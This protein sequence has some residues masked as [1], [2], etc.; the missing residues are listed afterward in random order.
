MQAGSHSNPMYAQENTDMAEAFDRRN[1]GALER[2]GGGLS[3]AD[4][5]RLSGDSPHP[6]LRVAPDGRIVYANAASRP[7]L[8]HWKS[9]EAGILPSGL[10]MLLAPL[11]KSGAARTVEVPCGDRIYSV[12]FVPSPDAGSIDLSGHDITPGTHEQETSRQKEEKYRT[13][14]ESMRQGVFYQRADG[15]LVDVNPSALEMFGLTREEFLGGTSYAPSWDVMREDGSPFLPEEHPS[16]LALATGML[17]ENVTL[18]VR[19]RRT[20]RYVWMIVNAIPQFHEGEEK[21]YQATVTLHDI[22]DRKRAEEEL[23]R[24]RDRAQRYLDIADV[25]LMALNAE[26][27]ITLINRKGSRILGYEDGELLDKV[28]VETC[29]PERIRKNVGKIFGALVSGEMESAEYTEN[30][31]LTKSG[32]ERIIAWHNLILKDEKGGIR[33]TFSSGEDITDRRRAEEA[34]RQSEEQLRTAVD[35]AGLNSWIVETESKELRFLHI[36]TDFKDLIPEGPISIE[37]GFRFVHPDDRESF[38]DALRHAIDT[39][40]PLTAECR[41][42]MPDGAL[43]WIVSRGSL[44]AGLPGITR[45][46]FAV[47]LDVTERKCAEESKIRAGKMEALGTLAGGIAH[48]FNNVLF[49]ISGNARLAI[50]DLPPTHPVQANLAEIEKASARAAD[51]VRRILSFSRPEGRAKDTM[52]LK[53]IVDE[54]LEFLRAMLPAMIEI[55]FDFVEDVPFVAC[56]PT[57]VHQ[58]IVNLAANASHAIGDRAGSIEA[59]LDAVTVAGGETGVAGLPKGRYARLTMRDDGC[60]MDKAIIQRIFD[61]FFTTKSAELGSGLGLSIVHAIMKSHGGAVTV[62]SE[63][64]KGSTFTLYF[65]EAQGM[66]EAPR[67]E[68]CEPPRGRGE[69]VL[70]IDDEEANVDVAARMLKRLGYDVTA[71]SD[72]ARALGM[73]RLRPLDFDAVVTDLAMPGMSGLDLARDVLAVRPDAAILMISGNASVEAQE[74]AKRIGIRELILKPETIDDLGRALDRLFRNLGRREEPRT[75]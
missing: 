12:A 57:Q 45:R 52:Q 64:G 24:E 23:G 62:E 49:A 56:D 37:R 16:M 75:A 31:V 4:L 67:E 29:L 22:T 60:G 26:G 2:V 27:R 5:A 11:L 9:G 42:L 28:W 68:E 61:P 3:I 32:E 72:P 19:N 50:T 53:P 48:D 63:P 18:A 10:K 15:V 7:L 8:E 39:A 51:L 41:V 13:L 30:P 70:F 59:R 66:P 40:E 34:L 35:V 54:A 47:T 14:F 44:I 38:L 17:V 65:P 6:V 20:A 1:K 71:C 74:A 55:R 25:M 43:R 46:F 69:H 58:V 36:T 21:P 73:F 33:G